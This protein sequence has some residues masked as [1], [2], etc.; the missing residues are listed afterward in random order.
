MNIRTRSLEIHGWQLAIRA[1]VRRARKSFF[2]RIFGQRTE[3]RKLFA[4]AAS[5]FKK[6][7]P[8]LAARL[9]WKSIIAS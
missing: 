9:C 2:G 7:K 1:R 4:G 8:D 6:R 5:I 3:A